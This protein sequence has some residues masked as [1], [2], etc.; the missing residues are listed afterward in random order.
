M[1]A[2]YDSEADA[3]AISVI[4][5]DEDHEPARGDSVHERCTVALVDG[6]VV[7][8]EILYPELG[9]EEPLGAAAARYDLDL[10]ALIAAARSSL[11]APDREI[12]LDV[13]ART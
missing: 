4:E 1:K 9:V 6:A 3:I 5:L 13:A 2:D 8:V 7:D 10:E 11:A 12:T